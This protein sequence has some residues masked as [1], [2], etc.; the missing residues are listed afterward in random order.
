MENAV[1]YITKEEKALSLKEMKK[2]LNNRLEHMK[3]I[4]NASGERATYINCFSQ[5]THKDFEDMRKF[6]HQDKGII[7]HHY[8]QSFQKDDNITPEQAHRI[9]TQLAEKMFNN[10]QV[11]IATHIDRDHIHNH[12]IVNSCN[13]ITGQKWHSNKRSLNEIRAESDKLCLQNGLG[14]INKNSKYEGIDR[15]TYQLGLKGKSWKVNLVK[16]LEQAI[17]VCKS[18]DDFISFMTDKDYTVKYMNRHI[19]ITKNGEKKGIRVDTLAKQFG[20]KYTKDNLEKKMGYYAE[21]SE[22]FVS[23]QKEKLPTTKSNWERYEQ[24]VFSKYNYE[25]SNSSNIIRDKKTVQLIN[26]AEK[27]S[28]V[29]LFELVIKAFL[30]LLG[31]KFRKRKT[32]QKV[33]YRKVKMIPYKRD[34]ITF[35]NINYNEL[36]NSYGENYTV[37]VTIDKLLRLANQPILYSALVNR[38]KSYATIT[39]KAK[40]REFL[41]RML[42]L[43]EQQNFL[44][45]QNEKISNQNTYRRLKEKAQLSECKLSYLMITE[46]QKKI[47]KDNYIEFAYFEKDG[48]INIAFMP[49]KSELI[50]K[51]IYPKKEEKKQETIQQKNNRIYAQLKK[52]AE[53]TGQKIGFKTRLTKA[54]LDS[55]SD[56]DLVFAYFINSEDKTM[57]NIAY[58]KKDDERINKILI[59]NKSAT[60]TR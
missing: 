9:G 12:I 54:Q 53:L 22:A 60:K 44:D 4:N 3:Q 30:M 45:D 38:E 37:R 57:Y 7:A 59:S 52:N 5:N 13:I 49:E 39:I 26:S 28:N 24:W 58:D 29:N 47:L 18:K 50:K 1:E 41:S 55:L 43:S 46:E 20:M 48:K 10:Y 19:T 21:P 25:K 16:D 34:N 35:G 32:F 17:S 42:G 40:D 36:V 15:A 6:F 31:I 2:Q 14:I 56:T 33:R 27:S 8:Y 11:V 23:P 51:L